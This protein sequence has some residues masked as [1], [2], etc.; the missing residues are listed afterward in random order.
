MSLAVARASR[1][2]PG[3]LMV[4]PW[5]IWLR[6][7]CTMPRVDDCVEDGSPVQVLVVYPVMGVIKLE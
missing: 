6:K 3:V 4:V 2:V 1:G 5:I 7:N